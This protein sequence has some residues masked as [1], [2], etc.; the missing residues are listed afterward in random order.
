MNLPGRAYRIEIGPGLLADADVRIARVAPTARLLV[1]ADRNADRLH[2]GALR[3]SLDRRFDN[4]VVVL[5]PGERTKSL[6]H[7]EKLYSA[8][9]E[10]RLTRHD[11]IVAFGGGVVGDLAG[12]VASTWLRGLELVM[13]PTTLLS[14]VDSSVGGKVGVNLGGVKNQVGAFHQPRLVISDTDCLETLPDREIRSALAE[15]VK[16]AMIADA[17]LLRRIERH[18][19]RI[20]RRDPV[21]LPGLVADCCRIKARIVA[22][23]ERE[24]GIRAVLNYGHTVGHAVEAAAGGRLRHGEAV[25]LGMRAAAAIAVHLGCMTPSDK[26]RQDEVLNRI[27]L[28]RKLAGVTAEDVMAKINND[29]KIQGSDVRFVLTRGIGSASLARPVEP[30][31]IRTAIGEILA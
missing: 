23:D 16:C 13:I 15:V 20:L 25:A 27:G 2:G 31:L 12:F 19:E 28:P 30:A 18:T 14:Q 26:Q 22:V 3:K 11:F 17:S 9:L 29:K 24:S 5:P 8:C 6:K 1:V 10:F 4:R 21:L 7:A